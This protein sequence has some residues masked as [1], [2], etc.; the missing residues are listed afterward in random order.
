VQSIARELYSLKTKSASRLK[1]GVP[2]VNLMFLPIL[3]EYLERT[4]ITEKEKKEFIEAKGSQQIQNLIVCLCNIN[5]VMSHARDYMDAV[6]AKKPVHEGLVPI[7]RGGFIGNWRDVQYGIGYGQYPADVNLE[8]LP[9]AFQTAATII[10]KI[11]SLYPNRAEIIELIDRIVTQQGLTELQRFLQDEKKIARETENAFSVL[12]NSTTPVLSAEDIRSRLHRYFTMNRSMTAVEHEWFL[13][14]DLG[15]GVKVRDFV[16]PDGPVPAILQRGVRYF[17]ASLSADGKP[18]ELFVSDALYKFLNENLAEWELLEMLTPLLLPYPVGLWT[19]AG[20]V[21]AS[22]VLSN[23][24]TLVREVNRNAYGGC[25]M[26]GWQMEFLKQG[27]IQYLLRYKDALP[28][29]VDKDFLGVLYSILLSCEEATSQ[30]SRQELW[31]WHIDNA[32]QFHSVP[33]G[34]SPEHND[35]SNIIQLWSISCTQT[36]MADINNMAQRFGLQRL[37]MPQVLDAISKLQTTYTAPAVNAIEP[38]S[39]PRVAMISYSLPPGGGGVNVVVNDQTGMLRMFDYPVTLIGGQVLSGEAGKVT[40][41]S[42]GTK[43]ILIPE[44]DVRSEQEQ[45]AWSGINKEDPY[46]RKE[47]ESLKDRLRESIK[48]ADVVLVHQMMSM[49]ANPVA[50]IALAELATEYRG[51]KRFIGWVHNTLTQQIHS[52]P[53]STITSCHPDIEYVAVS[54]QLRDATANLFY[55]PRELISVIPNSTGAVK[56]MSLTQNVLSFYL[57]HRLYDAEMIWFYPTRLERTKKLEVAIRAAAKARDMGKDIKLVIATVPDSTGALP[58]QGPAGQY[59]REL[60]DLI[61]S[62]NMADRV[63]FYPHASGDMKEISNWYTLSDALIFPSQTETFGIPVVEAGLSGTLFARVKLPETDALVGE[64]D[65]IAIPKQEHW[66]NDDQYANKFSQALVGRLTQNPAYTNAK[67]GQRRII[68]TLSTEAIFSTVVSPWLNIPP[69]EKR[70]IKSGARNFPKELIEDSITKAADAGFA[71]FEI[72]F[73]GFSPTDIDGEARAL[74]KETARRKNIK[75]ELRLKD[76]S[77][78]EEEEAARIALQEAVHFAADTGAKLITLRLRDLRPETTKLIAEEAQK[79]SH[80]G[81]ILSVE[82]F[83]STERT[84]SE[85]ELNDAFEG[86]P[87]QFSVWFDFTPNVQS[88]V[89]RVHLTVSNFYIGNRFWEPNSLGYYLEA[90]RALRWIRE[91]GWRGNVIIQSH[92]NTIDMRRALLDKVIGLSYVSEKVAKSLFTGRIEDLLPT[93][94]AAPVIRE[95]NTGTHLGTRGTYSNNPYFE[96]LTATF[97]DMHKQ[98]VREY[99]NAQETLIIKIENGVLTQINPHAPPDIP[100]NIL[101]KLQAH[102]ST[103]PLPAGKSFYMYLFKGTTKNKIYGRNPYALLDAEGE[104]LYAEAGSGGQS[105][106][107]SYRSIY[108]TQEFFSAMD[109]SML[110]DVLG[111]EAEHAIQKVDI[112]ERVQERFED[113]PMRTSKLEDANKL[114]ARHR[115]ILFSEMIQTSSYISSTSSAFL[116]SSEDLGDKKG[117]IIVPEEYL[118]EFKDTLKNKKLGDVKIVTLEEAKTILCDREGS[119]KRIVLLKKEDMPDYLTDVAACRVFKLEN[120]NFLHLCST[121]GLARAVIAENTNYIKEFYSLLLGTSLKD[122][123]LKVLLESRIIS[124]SLPPIDATLIKDIQV[125]RQTYAQ[126]LQSA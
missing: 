27:L 7:E 30:N 23:N 101:S 125:L 100:A 66:E 121:I 109:D 13:R 56:F 107:N 110:A 63:I 35:E 39:L 76:F 117:E 43:V 10:E 73:E 37:A 58:T 57:D 124:L 68:K 61:N 40:L 112:G 111:E 80:E 20:F 9:T 105:V 91:R 77:A 55:V 44:V 59:L 15:S 5:L 26:Y 54:P 94:V 4:D 17:P 122:D 1:Y 71:S 69:P 81:I 65:Q 86:T 119:E 32:G 47:I 96:D 11:R 41:E 84:L 8:L 118:D 12:R 48:D 98:F 106:G 74:I 102:L 31:T 90:S 82:N 88:Y 126:I 113:D 34:S 115:S 45:R 22:P 18:V 83:L 103:N 14:R 60:T 42:A 95:E 87:V 75:L 3:L 89:E 33:F 46:F 25:V 62:L 70:S 6:A 108:M 51:K 114:I 78:Y 116:E 49:P 50:T 28:E 24:E 79:A 92:I 19:P 97:D 52:W 120:Y 36:F 21:V 93:L 38:A 99:I 16:K 67:R 29:S 53:F 104:M 2:D 64:F 123:E 72:N 85:K